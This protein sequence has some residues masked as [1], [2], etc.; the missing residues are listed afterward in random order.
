MP[1]FEPP[2]V[3]E[4]P[5]VLE[6]VPPFPQGTPQQRLFSH[7]RSRPRGRTILLL[8]AGGCVALDYPTQMVPGD[9][10]E[11]DPFTESGLGPYLYTEIDRIFTGGHVYEITEE[12]ADRLTTCGYGSGI[13]PDSGFGE[14]GFGMD[15]FGG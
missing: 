14:G 12:E 11:G 7:Y 6:D 4:N 8:S 1:T 13:I 5:P 15:G 2:V 3:Y 10:A 9:P